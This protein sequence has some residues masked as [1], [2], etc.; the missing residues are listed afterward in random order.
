MLVLIAPFVVIGLW[1]YAY[2]RSCLITLSAP[3]KPV[4]L[5]Y[6]AAAGYVTVRGDSYFASL[7]RGT[8]F[9]THPQAIDPAGRLIAES[10]FIELTGLDLRRGSDQRIELLID[11]LSGKLVRNT[12]GRF[13]LTDYLPPT[14]VRQA[15]TPFH[16]IVNQADVLLVDQAGGGWE[17][18]AY[19]PRV[20]VVGAGSDWLAHG[21]VSLPGMGRAQGSVQNVPGDGVHVSGSTGEMHAERLLAHVLKLD[22]VRP[23]GPIRDLHV[24][25][26]VVSGPFKVFVPPGVRPAIQTQVT[27]S[28]SGLSL[29]R[30]A[31]DDLRFSGVVTSHGAQ[32][33]ATAA[34][35]G[36]HGSFSGAGDWTNGPSAAGRVKVT[37][38]SLGA[39]PSWIR[40]QVPR[41]A[42]FRQGSFSGWVSYKDR[43]V[44]V[45]GEA[46]AATASVANL[47][48]QL[49]RAGIASLGRSLRVDWH[50]GTID[51]SSGLGTALI[52][53]RNGTASGY[54]QVESSDLERFASVVG[55]KGLRGAG[56]ALA[57]VQGR[58]SSPQVSF[59][60][61]G[62]ASYRLGPKTNVGPEAVDLVG[63][64]RNGTVVVE[65][66]VLSGR[67]GTVGI[68][69]RS[70]TSA[71]GIAMHIDGRDLKADD[72][73]TGVTGQVDLGAD[74]T[75][76][77]AH[78]KIKGRLEATDLAYQGH[79][80]A[81]ASLDFT[82]DRTSLVA[83]HVAAVSGTMDL[84]G[85][86]RYA[87]ESGALSG[88]FALN[89]IQATEFL[90]DE[91][92]GVID[93][94]SVALSGTLRRP[95]VSANFKAKEVLAH[96]TVVR[97]I[98]GL[99]HADRNGAVVD[100]A[101]ADIAGGQVTASGD[102]SWR[103]RTGNVSASA[104]NMDLT[105]LAA[106]LGQSVEIA[107]TIDIGSAHAS[108]RGKE[109]NGNAKGRLDGV[110]VNGIPVGDGQWTLAKTGE[111]LQ[112]NVS[113][114]QIQPVLRAVDADVTY[115]LSNRAIAGTLD[116]KNIRVEELV[117]SMQ[118]YLPE[119][120]ASGPGSL[121]PLSGNVTLEAKVS[122]D[123]RDPSIQIPTLNA[124]NITYQGITFGN[125]TSTGAGREHDSWTIPSLSLVGPQGEVQI[126]GSVEEHGR[127][128]L[129]GTGSDLALSALAPFAP[130]LS[131]SPGRASL[132][133]KATG[134]TLHPVLTGSGSVE[135]IAKAPTNLQE[136]GK[137]LND[138]SVQIPSFTVDDSKIEASGT[139]Q[140]AGFTGK[141]SG[142]VPFT[143]RGGVGHG[144]ASGTLTLDERQL[145]DLPL[146]G[147]Y[148]DPRRLSGTL[149][150]SITGS[151]PIDAMAFDG[152][153][154]LN[155]NI[156][157]VRFPGTNP[158]VRKIDD[159][160]AN[161]SATL[162]VTTQRSLAFTGKADL[163]RGGSIAVDASVPIA[164]VGS[165]LRGET[166]TFERAMLDEPING[167][168]SLTKAKLRQSAPGGYVALV[169]DGSTTVSGSLARPEIGSAT[170]PGTFTLNQLD[171]VIPALPS[172]SISTG[173]ATF[174]PSFYLNAKIDSTAR[175]RSATADLTLTGGGS[176][177]GPLS[178][179][180]AT[181]DLIVQ[182]GTIML[183][184][185][186]VRLYQGGTVDFRYRHPFGDVPTSSLDVDLTGR[187]ALTAIRYGQ[188]T[189][190]YTIT[191]YIRGD[192]LRADALTM[193]A[194]SDPP[195]LTSQDV[196]TLLGEGGVFEGLTTTVPGQSPVQQRI[197]DALAG[198]AVPNVLNPVTSPIARSLGLDY[199]SLEYNAYDQT[200][201]AA[202]RSLN[203]DFS[204]MYRGQIG[205]PTPG[206]RPIED[207]ELVY[208]PH[209]L[210]GNLRHLSFSLGSD[211]DYPWKAA[212]TYG[213]RFGPRTPLTPGPKTII[214]APKSSGQ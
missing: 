171:T 135:H 7:A 163:E 19:S 105:R 148:L 194:I 170:Q 112:G 152:G 117:G 202:S 14:K 137:P 145:A 97:S 83:N 169:A 54:I 144:N 133:L 75:G 18:P 11:H 84:A 98:D 129:T 183:P 22:L 114:G 48:G 27:A 64:Y 76:S 107:G 12:S 9:V 45:R 198:F 6:K 26:L 138:L 146:L 53:T 203:E 159:T 30:Y 179:P 91:F 173:P 212:I 47:S 143:Y 199:L 59:V 66:G 102:Y 39:L 46:S 3:G 69:G 134:E 57:F 172:G 78:P 209:R 32:G 62:N 94:P 5:R 188:T 73:V 108:V 177:R 186:T 28:A 191:L 34:I 81:A 80:V 55:A 211:Q 2:I 164:D 23:L 71:T 180:R 35:G 175:V 61:N 49:L 189:Q 82:G 42:G 111:A 110:S 196:L 20:E 121:A 122:G 100:R 187:T 116:V 68:S 103:S 79:S 210:P 37:A 70:G 115:N 123:A 131:S 36:A 178:D 56:S 205:S 10:R 147:P 174:D 86:A 158:Y 4:L 156:L 63:T 25:T 181:A 89:G 136:T 60:A 119:S 195:D 51:G 127:I 132:S 193:D 190:R 17:Q 141:V 185:G 153:L 67:T 149:G 184:G 58:L 204:V 21:Q 151:G 95:L 85:S 165:V 101:T 104:T 128:A 50:G 167:V 176:L 87:Y 166:N 182:R 142:S 90:G 92:A 16:V 33:T 52:D 118:K 99:V 31:V 1:S 24:R 40:A 109:I 88:V 74:V 214:S 113:V 150:G 161:V 154:N 140:F 206:L 124:Q 168:I 38:A 120:L 15:K 44:D 160:L 155:A 139:Y 201:I 213:V 65:R 43:R 192:L 207:F 126:K 197:T 72:F 200:T 8:V 13:E 106:S 162:H 157:G 96:E 208:T 130:A 93:A 41:N 29:G 77:F 125:L